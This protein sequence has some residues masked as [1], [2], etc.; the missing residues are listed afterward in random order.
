M[1]AWALGALS[2][3]LLSSASA[4]AGRTDSFTDSTFATSAFATFG[5]DSAPASRYRALRGIT[6]GPIES[7]MQ[8][9]RGYGSKA[10]EQTLS[11]V[12]HLGG[13]WISLT[14]F[15]RVWDLDSTGVEPSFE[16]PCAETRENIR[17]SVRLAHQR[18][19]RVLLVPHLWV[20][21]RKWRAELDPG[22]DAGWAKW[23]ASYRRFLLDWA[24]IAED[25]A[26]D[27]FAV[28]VELR[29]WVTTT[30]APSFLPIVRDVRRVYQGPLT[31]AANWDDADDTVI[32]GEL[33]V[34]G[35]NAFYQLHW[36][37]DAT[38]QQL[39]AG[40]ER[41]AEQV[42]ALGRRYDKPVIFTEFGYIARKNTA[43]K[44]WLWPEELGQVVMDQT[45]QEDAYG[46]LLAAMVEVPEFAGLF[47]WRMY[48]D[49]AD[50]S[51]EPD[52]G[53]S[54]WGK[55]AQHVLRGAYRGRFAADRG[56]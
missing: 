10:F 25:S 4:S 26:V 42:R 23:A 2:L 41:V 33:D 44:P 39:A 19:L 15:G 3:L 8:P 16:A 7:Q 52:W 22:S 5:P 54:P 34:V 11:E 35:I 40:G 37:D 1:K 14:V 18:G 53:F 27:L 46:A 45:A 31:Y 49:L 55:R 29:S 56:P 13:N 36:E 30:R 38:T 51:Q 20:E 48:A 17:R 47:V 28:G 9:G 21:S 24:Q 43:I 6:L 32:W 50:L 12:Q